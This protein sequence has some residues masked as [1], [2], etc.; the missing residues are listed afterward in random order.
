MT[1]LSYQKKK[2]TY[3]SLLADESIHSEYEKALKITGLGLRQHHPMY[4]GDEAVY[5]GEEFQVRSPIDQDILIGNFQKGGEDEARRA[6]QAAKSAFHEWSRT[7]WEER[8]GI[9]RSVGEMMDQ[10]KFN[11]A[12]LIT[13]EVGK[14]RY[15]AIAEVGEA[16]DF[17]RYYA[18]VYEQHEGYLRPTRSE[19]PGEHCLSVMRPHGV[20]AVIS[21][22][23]FPIALGAGMCAGALL[24]G[25]TVVLKPTSS[26]PL[27]GLRLYQ[28]FVSSGIPPGAIN[29]VTGPGKPFG[30]VIVASPDVDG[31]A[32]TGSREVGTWLTRGFVT[33]QP[34]QKPVVSELGSKNPCIVTAKADLG[35]AAEGVVKAAFG[36]GGQKCSATSRVYVHASVAADFTSALKARVE[37]LKVGD[38]REKEVFIGPLINAAALNKFSDAVGATQHDLEGTAGGVITGGG[39][40]KEGPFAKGFYA[41][42]TV[43]TDLPRGHRLFR[44]ELFVP[45]LIVDTYNSLDEALAQANNTEYGLTAGIFSEDE[46]EIEFFFDHIQFGVCYA[47]RMGGATTGAWPGAQSFGGWKASGSTGRGV[48]GPYYLLSFLREQAQTRVS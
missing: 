26:A 12:A 40:L 25:N 14:N 39:V 31:I 32:F 13:Y 6:V 35:K 48:G 18:D 37:G 36:Y 19:V 17:F 10:E 23:N 28:L 7:G 44:E 15:E 42:P 30:E 43:A 47:N 20:W 38:P 21:P 46:S 16:I 11:L 8:S 34:Y 24:T 3:V 22:F 29:V 5:A 1:K 9:L 41:S 33:N 45:F 27:S 4:I 2:I